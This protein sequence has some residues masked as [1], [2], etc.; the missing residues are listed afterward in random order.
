MIPF[1]FSVTPY[2]FNALALFFVGLAGILY[3][4][5]LKKK[6]AAT[7][8][9]MLVMFSFALGMISWLASS[10][11]FWGGAFM[12]FTDAC[13]VFS[14]AG[15]MAFTYQY[16]QKIDSSEARLV[17]AFAILISTIALFA[18]LSYLLQYIVTHNIPQWMPPSLMVSLN[19]VATL[20]AMAACVRR[21]QVLQAEMQAVQNHKKESAFQ[22]SKNRPMRLLRNFAL[23]ILFGTVQGLA[24]FLGTIQGFPY[25]II[26]LLIDLSFSLMFIIVVYSFFDLTDE[27]PPLVVRLVGLSFVSVLCLSGIVGLYVYDMAGEWTYSRIQS[28]V[29]IAQL[30]IDDGRPGQLSPNIAYIRNTGSQETGPENAEIP[31]FLYIRHDLDTTT[32]EFSPQEDITSPVWNYYFDFT[33]ICPQDQPFSPE[34]HY[35]RHPF[36]SYPQYLGCQVNIAGQTIEIGILLD[37]INHAIMTKCTWVWI[38]LLTSGLLV[39]IAFPRYFRSNLIHP[40]D[41]LLEGVHQADA[42]NLDICVPI[43]YQDEVGIITAAFNKMAVNLQEELNQRRQAEDNLRQLNLT[44]E[45]RVADRTHELEALYDISTAASQAQDSSTLLSTLLERS[46]TAL[47]CSMGMILLLDDPSA[48]GKLH[49]ASAS[50]LTT[51]WMHYYLKPPADDPLLMGAISQSDPLLIADLT[52]EPR[53]PAFIREGE[54]LTMI[55]APLPAD[56]QVFGLMGLIRDAALAFDFNEIALLVSIVGQVGSAVQTDHLRQLAQHASL[57]E[58]RQRLSRDLHDSVTQSL[59]GLSTLTEAG[60]L[61]LEQGNIDAGAHMLNRIGQTARQAIREMRLFLHQLRPSI[62]EQEGL[63]NALEMRLAAVEGRSDIR[64]VLEADENIHLPLAVET[65]LYHIA[66]EALNNTL[67]H[68]SASRVCVRLARNGNIV[69]LSIEDDGCGFDP[70]TSAAGGMGLENM[71]ARAAEINANLDIQSETG[72]GTLVKVTLENPE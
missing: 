28:D 47:A 32:L 30:A 50:A 43:S 7:R 29:G 69:I 38:V 53:A 40:L 64:T 36:G 66:Q 23:A 26:P 72:K 15:V 51:P 9:I 35:G 67:K 55:L 49:L 2:S 48:P 16:P 22:L 12:P 37:D 68:A 31:S 44:L 65:A 52:L 18:S 11:V 56:G 25:Q 33:K 14:M 71:H 4:L 8:L 59:Y 46:L 45:Q 58:E 6:S 20:G 61:N 17:R 27:Q 34:F 1:Q 3:L 54:A 24:P 57:L 62:L 21:A 10:I 63:V 70:T 13:A 42:G 39:L 60:K 5:P 19:A 41:N